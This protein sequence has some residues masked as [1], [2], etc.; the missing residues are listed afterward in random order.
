MERFAP[1]TEEAAADLI[2]WAVAEGQPLA[3]EGN[4]SKASLGHAVEASHLISTGSLNGITLY[5]P[6]ELVL[7]AKAGTSLSEISAALA[8]NNQQFAF[9]PPSF[10]QLYG[11]NQPPTLGGL[12]AS[13][14]S[15]PRRIAVGAARDHTLGVRCV[16]GRGEVIKAGGRVV[17]NVTG[18]DLPKLLAGSFGT[19]G[20]MTEITV[21]VLPA[22]ETER[23]LVVFG[24]DREALLALLRRLTGEGIEASGFAFLPPASAKLSLRSSGTEAAACIRLEGFEKSVAARLAMAEALTAE[25]LG[26]AAEQAVLGAEE[27][28]P[29]WEGVREVQPLLG[30]GLEA[31]LV[32]VSLPPTAAPA[33]LTFIER[34]EAQS[35]ADWAGGQVWISLADE[36]AVEEAMGAIRKFLRAGSEGQPAPGG[37]ATLMRAAERVRQRVPVFQPADG[38]LAALQARVK[39]SFDPKHI[40]NP[41]RMG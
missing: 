40:L 34:F 11:T 2:T 12:I 7:S 39:E 38:P 36:N 17:K 22:A 37:H 8:A 10:N 23:T 29:L 26:D 24:G 30:H 32:R 9:E 21:K 33:L 35:F 31:A 19:L 15:G 20:L 16:H 13:N 25:M 4:G 5:E 14:A 18:Y 28:S 1:D 6:D 27:S 41:G 3:L